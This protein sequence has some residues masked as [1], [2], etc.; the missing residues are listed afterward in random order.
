VIPVEFVSPSSGALQA[1]DAD[2]NSEDAHRFR[3]VDNLLYDDDELVADGD[4][5][6][7]VDEEP[8]TYGEAAER[9]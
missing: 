7:A 1:L 3:V 5:L 9:Q 4:L 8:S 2:D 6:L